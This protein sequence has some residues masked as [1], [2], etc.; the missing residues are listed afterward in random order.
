MRRPLSGCRRL[1]NSYPGCRRF[2]TKYSILPKRERSKPNIAE[3]RC[4]THRLHWNSHLSYATDSC[5]WHISST[6]S[7]TQT[8]LI[9]RLLGIM[10]G[11]LKHC[12]FQCKQMTFGVGD[13]RTLHLVRWMLEKS[14]NFISLQF[15][16]WSVHHSSS[17][18]A[19][20]ALTQNV[21]AK[22]VISWLRPRFHE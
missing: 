15:R 9:D 6:H 4:A 3:V 12:G 17:Y 20:L 16:Y 21:A 8:L 19:A 11:V 7:I 22:S 1:L 13:H 10:D 2:K 5:Q 14:V 18:C